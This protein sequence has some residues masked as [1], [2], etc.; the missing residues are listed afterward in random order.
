MH[1]ADHGDHL[2]ADFEGSYEPAGGHVINSN[3]EET[4]DPFSGNEFFETLRCFG[5][6]VFKR[7]CHVRTVAPGEVL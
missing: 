1:V 2:V 7:L 5:V 6:P 4:V 3:S